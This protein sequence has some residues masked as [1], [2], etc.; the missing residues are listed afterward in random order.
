MKPIV[1]AAVITCSLGLA[2]FAVRYRSEVRR[3]WRQVPSH[4][5]YWEARNADGEFSYLSLG[6]SSAQ[7]IGVDD[8][9]E[10]YVSVLADRLAEREGR[11][12]AV[13]NL[14]V[15]GATVGSLLAKQIPQLEGLPQPDVCTLFIGGNDMIKR[16]FDANRFRDRFDQVLSAMPPGTFVGELPTFGHWPFEPRVRTANQI[17]ADLV[18]KHGHHL[19]PLYATSRAQWP[20]RM[21]HHVNGDWFHPNQLG[22]QLWADTYWRTMIDVLGASE[23]RVA[24]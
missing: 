5:E 7:G 24:G 17:I 1:P 11:A 10:G 3:L 13:R 20:F 8:P 4:R 2:A 21:F 12:V 15:S 14:S 16:S 19:V 22:Y 9:G 6:D 23:A 18:P